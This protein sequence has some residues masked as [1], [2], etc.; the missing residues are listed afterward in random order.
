M[1]TMIAKTRPLQKGQSSFSY[2]IKF[3]IANVIIRKMKS[4]KSK[5]RSYHVGGKTE[6]KT[7]LSGQYYPL[8]LLFYFE[9][10]WYL[11]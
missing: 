7:M 10:L 2:L 8:T 1:Y 5:I 4:A 6:G 11:N 9:F 3:E